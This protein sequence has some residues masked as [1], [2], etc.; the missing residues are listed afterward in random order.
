MKPYTFEV[1]SN[2][3][4]YEPH[5][6]DITRWYWRLRASNGKIVAD[7]SEG[8]SSKSAAQKAVRRIWKHLTEWGVLTWREA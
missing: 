2:T 7:G 4:R 8:Y 6:E 3:R 5:A 1:F